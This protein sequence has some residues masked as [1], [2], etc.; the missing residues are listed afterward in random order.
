MPEQFKTGALTALISQLR[1][2]RLDIRV[3]KTRLQG[4][5]IMYIHV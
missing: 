2:Y 3:Q 4:K 1:E 5:D